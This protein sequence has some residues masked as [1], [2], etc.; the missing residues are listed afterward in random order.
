MS[1]RLVLGL[2]AGVL[3]L[4]VLGPFFQSN[5]RRAQ[6]R[7]VDA[8]GTL[9][10]VP[11]GVGGSQSASLAGSEPA[12]VE[13]VERRELR[14]R[15][16]Y[17]GD[18]EGELPAAQATF[19]AWAGRYL[20]APSA[21]ARLGLVAEGV[22]LARVRRT[23]MRA[24]IELD[25]ERALAVTPPLRIRQA[26][27]SA[28]QALLEVRL[29][30][31]GELALLAAVPAADEPEPGPSLRRVV[32]LEGVTRTAFV[33]G[34]REE[35][36]SKDGAFLH[37]IALDQL[38]A[39]HESPL[40]LPERE[41]R[42]TAVVSSGCAACGESV[43]SF[44]SGVAVEERL[45]FVEVAGQ[46]WPLHDG[47]AELAG[48]ERRLIQAEDV[49][50]PRVELAPLAEA[51][52]AGAGSEG[53]GDV[54][55]TAAEAPTAQTTGVKKV[56]VL[57]VDF[58]DV[59]GVVVSE[60]TAS[61][62]VGELA[63]A[64]MDTNSYGLTSMVATVS[65]TVY[66]LPQTASAYALANNTAGLHSD[67][68]TAASADFA[69]ASFDRIIV[70][71]PSIGTSRIPGSQITFG[72][73]A[74]LGGTNVWINGS[75]SFA[76][77]TIS[78]ELGHSYGLPHANLWK[79]TDGDAQSAGGTTIEYGDPFDM[80]G[81]N[82]VT[83]VTRTT[84]HHYSPWFK[85][86]LGWLPDEAVTTVAESG[87]YRIHRYDS[88][89][90][91]LDRPLALR[92][93]RDGVR[94]YWVGL[95]QNF[96]EGS[97]LS[98]GAYV[99]WGFNNRQQSQLLDLVTP[100]TSAN[101]ASLPMGVTFTDPVSGVSITPVSRGGE[102]PEQWLDVRVTFPPGGAG[103]VVAAWGREGALF[104]AGN[105][106]LP[107]N[108]PPETYVPQGLRGV[109]Q[110][111]AGD[112]H[113]LALRA[114]GSVV[115]WGDDGNGQAT[116]PSG[117]PPAAAVLAGGDV[118]GIIT[119]EGALRLWGLSTGGL[120]TPPADLGPV[121]QAAIGRNHV[122][123]LRTDGRVVAW[124][125]NS[126]GQSTV[127]ADLESVVAVAAGTE[128]SL[129][130]KADGTVAAW[131]Y[132][133]VRTLPAGLADVAEV[134]AAGV[135]N[136]GQFAVARKRDGTVVAWGV[137]NTGQTNVPAGLTRV[138]D[139][140]AGAFH[141]LAVTDEG[142]VVA[143][144]QATGGR[145]VVP[146]ALPYGTAVAA[147]A[148]SSF[149]LLGSPVTLLRAPRSHTLT[150]GSGV[151]LST[152][153]RGLGD[154]SYQW[155]RD[156]VPLPGAT[157]ASLTLTG[158]TAG[159]AGNYDVQIRDA[160]AAYTL[161]SPAAAVS[162]VASSNPGRLINLSL[163]AALTS[164]A[165]VLTVGTVIGGAAT[166]GTKPLL[167]RAVG[168]SL[169]TFG[170]GGLLADPAMEFYAD[171]VR[172]GTNDDWGGT[173]AL[174]SSFAAVGAFPLM[175]AASKDAALFQ[176]AIAPGGK[177]VRVSGTNG[178]VGMVLTELYDATPADA[179][180]PSTPRLINVSVLKEIG[181][182]FTV[183]F[184]VGGTTSRSVLVRA[185]G[186][187]LAG[188]GVPVG[189]APNPRLNFFAGSVA[190]GENDDWSDAPA[191]AS[192][193]GRVGAF[194][195]PAGSR[196]ASLLTTVPPGS[197]SVQVRASDGQG[198][199]VLVEVYEVP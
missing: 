176:P 160:R 170:V 124:G 194:P 129:A 56:L 185:V 52:R 144:G 31:R 90:A 39:V 140:A 113:A 10:S 150:P 108:P 96:A 107:T 198:G 167:V 46:A 134:A 88:R 72:G 100:G 148:S 7:A 14:R 120:T 94:W 93:F 20:R 58:S 138:V 102:D 149:A 153:A 85:N 86:R 24:L 74:T 105:T 181:A 87:V 59:P 191:L 76:F 51:A 172:T 189:Y 18:W 121:R 177:S 190:S 174:A 84:R 68:R 50:G 75:G 164:P 81:S 103:D 188:V 98:D 106:G 195:L 182:G 61:S 17:G 161:T 122:V 79:V 114:D 65:P 101:D 92:V 57:R 162:V 36:L 49:A 104:F 30:G 118:S 142:R 110:V 71:F 89:N 38:M 175:S 145:T 178:A 5:G 173:T 3:A 132:S 29:S 139:I 83:G 168:P 11:L 42:P 163:L 116:V 97:P 184:V 157:S 169:A 28:V 53:S 131:G 111:A 115:G 2:A 23:S 22:E 186:P 37:G 64:F 192:T 44:P 117:L 54:P 73:L 155:R 41:E 26:L 152:E 82:T 128:F 69:V 180:A 147:S 154:L 179:Y 25:P 146:P 143:W 112:Q 125:S 166:V 19:R 109:V 15:L 137:N 126:L 156:G 48:V 196:D 199:L 16:S 35:Q 135:L 78:H 4:L 127:P 45:G 197:Y 95:R 8:D 99:A 133:Q 151:T 130:L 63:S 159:E 27:P 13:R 183:G 12:E 165:E 47:W 67:A 62:V 33:Y 80:M 171:A 119:R 21:A 9:R 193:A 34:R 40:R 136:G 77:T 43:A 158:L 187:G 123:A 60:S 1:R 6:P 70:A 66:R 55:S 91:R 32:Y 141:A